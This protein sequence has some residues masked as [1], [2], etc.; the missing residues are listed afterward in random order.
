MRT[1]NPRT[2]LHY[3]LLL[4]DLVDLAFKAVELVQHIAQYLA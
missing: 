3:A 4:I 1:N 2:A